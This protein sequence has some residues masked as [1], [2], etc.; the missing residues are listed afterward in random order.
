LTRTGIAAGQTKATI[1][2]ADALKGFETYQGGGP[3]TLK[4]VLENAYDE[5]TSAPR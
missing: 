3:L 4:G 2:A 1:A 5:L